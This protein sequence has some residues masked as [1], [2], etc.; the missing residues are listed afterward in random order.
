MS[1]SLSLPQRYKRTLQAMT[2]A[3]AIIYMTLVLYQNAYG[4]PNIQVIT[5]FMSLLLFPI[6]SNHNKLRI[7]RSYPRHFGTSPP[8]L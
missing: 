4:Y 6:E 5:L 2:L 8:K 7:P 1:L 3:V